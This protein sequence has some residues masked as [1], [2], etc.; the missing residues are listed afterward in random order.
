MFELKTFGQEE[1]KRKIYL[2]FS[3]NGSGGS[4]LTNVLINKDG[5][6]EYLVKPCKVAQDLNECEINEVE[7]SFIK[8][9]PKYKETD[10]Y[11]TQH[12]NLIE[13]DNYFLIDTISLGSKDITNKMVYNDLISSLREHEIEHIDYCLFV[14]SADK[15]VES[16]LK[17]LK[18]FSNYFL[19]NFLKDNVLL[20]ITKTSQIGDWEDKVAHSELTRKIMSIFSHRYI[21]FD[22]DMNN[23]DDV[24]DREKRLRKRQESINKLLK[25]IKHFK[26]TRFDVTSLTSKKFPCIII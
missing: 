17:L 21:E 18:E 5:R 1:E 12:A 2:I 23:P 22:L 20:V 6:V 24:K 8:L 19:K 25:D 14:I 4:T 9:T 3:I 7:D 26:F 11:A 10:K 16:T 13:K 15:L